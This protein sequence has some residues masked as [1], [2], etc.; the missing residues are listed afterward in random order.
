[1][2][3][4]PA[5]TA[6]PVA[7]GVSYCL[8]HSKR[9]RAA[10]SQFV[11]YM[12]TKQTPHTAKELRL[13]AALIRKLPSRSEYVTWMTMT[14]DELERASQQT[15]LQEKYLKELSAGLIIKDL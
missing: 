11:H 12:A 6:G 9:L 8:R 4:L 13:L 14:L 1:M 2:D 10:E 7:H 3:K 15:L 5:R